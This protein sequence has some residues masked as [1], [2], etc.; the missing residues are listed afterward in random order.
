MPPRYSETHKKQ[1]MADV[2]QLL[3]KAAI[4]EFAHNGFDGA[5]INTIS[6]KAGFSKG[7]IYNYFPSKMDL[8]LAILDES[9][10]AHFDF[11]AGEIRKEDDPIHRIE[12]FFEAGFEFVEEVELFEQNY[13]LKFRVK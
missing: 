8:M 12:R 13:F 11:I 1:A 10:S 3:I 6:L 4:Q 7:T 9:G 2:R 5:N